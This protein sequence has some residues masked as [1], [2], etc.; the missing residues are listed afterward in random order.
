MS[1]VRL[2]RSELSTPA[3]NAHMLQKAAASQ[4][5]L[6]MLDL[7]DSVSPAE[8]DKARVQAIEALRS[9][10]WAGKTRAVRINDLESEYAYRDIIALVEEAGEHLDILIVPKVKRARDVW[11]V[12]RLLTQIEKR[13][14]LTRS[15]G[16]EVLIEETEALI[17]VEKIARASPRLEALIF[18]PA[19]YAAS[20][21]IDLKYIGND[22]D[23]YPGDLWHYARNKIVIAA[24]AAGLEAIDGPYVNIR[25]LEGYRRE[26]L[27]AS[28]LGFS[29]KWAIHP[30]QIPIANEVFSPVPEQVA[31][32]RR[33]IALY[34]EAQRT[35]QGAIEVDGRMIDMALVRN[36]RQLIARAELLGR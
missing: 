7:E 1:T 28:V 18:G 27:R 12:D 9:L 23:T 25:N 6:V 26:C 17:N 13:C 35:G 10:D 29:G 19:D 31:Q 3:S 32:A 20:Q 11:W 14:R 36:A 16:L 33:L 15:I 4:A 30:E 24:R 34:E 21:G 22:F 2:R 5:D 8:K